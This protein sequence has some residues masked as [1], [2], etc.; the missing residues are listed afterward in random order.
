[1]KVGGGFA[2]RNGQIYLDI[3]IQNNSQ[4]VLT[5]FEL[6]FNKNI[7]TICPA[8]PIDVASLNPGQSYTG[9]VLLCFDGPAPD[10]ITPFLH[11]ALKNNVKVH[12]FRDIIPFKLLFSQDGLLEKR[13]FLTQWK[14]LPKSEEFT[15]NVDNIAS[16]NVEMISK[17]L[18]NH[19]VFT[20]T[21]TRL[22]KE[23]PTRHV[24]YG[25]AALLNG[26][27]MLI[28]V[29]FMLDQPKSC[30]VTLKSTNPAE[31]NQFAN[32]LSSLLTG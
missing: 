24:L 32:A 1:M 16:N 7:F 31:Y 19:N 30:K 6:Q 3:I 14:S 21:I 2:R 23:A 17:H 25:S 29:I 9:S 28:E 8:H 20:V 18:A 12:F 11:I 10:K 26:T 22:P 13:D 15:R 4:N 27:T 5:E